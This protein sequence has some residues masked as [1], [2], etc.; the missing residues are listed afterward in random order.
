MPLLWYMD[1]ID[2]GIYIVS[3]PD[4]NQPCAILEAIYTGVGLGP[5]PRLVFT[6]PALA[7]ESDPSISVN[8]FLD[9][10]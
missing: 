5:G 9:G 3:A 7:E 10:Y 4:P 1:N 8:P 2:S 6:P